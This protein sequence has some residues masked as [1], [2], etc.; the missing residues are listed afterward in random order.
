MSV[1]PLPADIRTRQRLPTGLRVLLWAQ[2]GAVS[3]FTIVLAQPGGTAGSALRDVLLGNVVLVLPAAVMVWRGCAV[4]ADRVWAWLLAGGAMSFIGGNIAYIGWVARADPPPFPSVADIGY[5]GVYPTFVAAIVLSLRATR[6]RVRSSVALDGLV[7]ALGASAAGAWAMSPLLE[8]LEGSPAQLVVSAAYPVGDVLIVAMCVGVLVL[9]GGRPGGVY[10]FLV[11]GL[12]MFAVADIVY[13][14][15]VA[16]GT[17]QIGTPLD[18]LW[19]LG[20]VVCAAGVWRERNTRGAAPVVGLSSLWVVA[21][22]AAV[23]LGVLT[24]APALHAPTYVVVLATLTLVAAGARTTEAFL[25]VRDMAVVTQQAHT[26]ELTQVGNRRIL[27]EAIDQTLAGLGSATAQ[28]AG[29]GAALALL[30]LDRFK[31]VNDTLG[32]QAGDQL[33]IEVARRLGEAIADLQPGLVL[34]RLGGDEFAVLITEAA[35]P[36]RVAAVAGAMQAALTAPV[37][38]EGMFLH[39]QGSIG[40]ALA[41]EHAANRSDLLRCADLA[42]YAAKRSDVP[43]VLFTPAVSPTSRETLQLAED[44]HTAVVTGALTVAFQPLVDMAGQ[45]RGAEVL[46]RWDH[47]TR[48]AVP[49]SEFLPIAENRKLMPRLTNLV[50]DAALAECAIWRSHGHLVPVSVNLSAADLLDPGLPGEVSRALARHHV[51]ASALICEITETTVMSDP[52]RAVQTLYR[53]RAL[54]VELAI[55]DYGTGHC[56]LAY[57]RRL[58]VQTLKLDRAF[59]TRAA[60]DPR[61][62][63]IVRSTLALAHALGLRMVAEGVEDE[64][65]A[66]LL[67]ALGCDLAQGFYFARPMPAREFHQWCAQNI[68]RSRPHAG[69]AVPSPAAEILPGFPR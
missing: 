24:L 32:H 63:A 50:L 27:N 3:V 7:G 16:S 38:V 56:S 68:A 18:A 45:L 22:S 33:L 28:E 2:L 10:A 46:V 15:R 47:P 69:V 30:D 51:P 58:P 26:D 65:S 1:P 67:A 6:G 25:R 8:M 13:A 54:G 55:D 37:V 39:V 19:A 43:T 20:F 49:P 42:M 59:V 11:A 35:G 21:V 60:D 5:L 14:Y 66:M 62:T 29:R 52:E 36:D 31:E 53:L 9:T 17:Y 4:P 48:G 23:A 64:R 57:L 61:D 34:A 12:L 41:P 44:L 40:V